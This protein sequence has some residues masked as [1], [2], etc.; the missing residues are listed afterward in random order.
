[1]NYF[2]QPPQY[3]LGESFTSFLA[4]FESFCESIDAKD[5]TRKHVFL[6]SLPSEMKFEMQEPDRQLY[7]LNFDDLLEKANEVAGGKQSR[8]ARQKLITRCQE[9]GE[10]NRSFVTALHQLGELAYPEKADSRIKNDVLYNVLL[11]GLRDKHHVDRLVTSNV[12]KTDSPSFLETA[13]RL[14]TFDGSSESNVVSVIDTVRTTETAELKNVVAE[15]RKEVQELR[16]RCNFRS[17]A[18]NSPNRNGRFHG[19][20]NVTCYG[21]GRKG[22]IR[23][24]C[25][26]SRHRVYE[27]EGDKPQQDGGAPTAS[28]P[29]SPSVT[30]KVSTVAGEL[31][32][33][34]KVIVNS[35]T[36]YAL[37]DT[38]AAVTVVSES[39]FQSRAHSELMKRPM[40][41][42]FVGAGGEPLSITGM[43]RINIA[44]GSIRT[45]MIVYV[46][47]NLTEDCI[48]GLDFLQDHQ[49]IVDYKH[50]TL[51]AGNASVQLLRRPDSSNSIRF[52]CASLIESLFVP[53][54]T[55]IVVSCRV[56]DNFSDNDVV[57]V[58]RNQAFFDKYEILSASAVTK[59]RDHTTAQVKL[60]NFT[61]IGKFLPAGTNV[62]KISNICE[63]HCNDCDFT[64]C[65]VSELTET[66]QV[67]NGD[68]DDKFSFLCDELGLNELNVSEVQRDALMAV[69]KKHIAAFSLSPND[70]GQT[71]Q[72][73]HKIDTGDSVP[74]RQH[75]RRMSNKQKV[76]V[77]KLVDEMCADGIISPS[78]SPWSSPIVLVKKKDGCFRFCVDYRAVNNCTKKNSYP[79]PRVD[80]SLDQLSGCGYFTTLDLKAGYW[81]IPMSQGDKEKTAFT[82]HKGLF[83]FNVMP[84]GLA[85]APA[86]FQHLMRIV[87]NGIEWNGVLAY[88]DDIIVYARTF[89]AHLQHL[90][91]LL[92]R[93][94][95]HGLKL[96]PSKC[97][98]L[99]TEVNFLGH[100][101]SKSGVSC[102]PDKISCI[103]NWPTP[104]NV[105]DVQKFLGLASYYRK[106]VKDFAKLAA[107]L[108]DITKNSPKSFCWSKECNDVFVFLKNALTTAPVLKY[109]DF[110]KS[111]IVDTDASNT[112]VG[113]VL[114]QV[115]DGLEH[116]VAYAS[117]ALNK[118]ERNYSTTRKEL[119]AVVHALQKFRCYLDQPF[120]LRTDH[121]SLRWLWQAKDTYGQCARWF[122][123]LAEFDFKLVHRAGAKHQNADAL[124]R[125]PNVN[126]QCDAEKC[127]FEVDENYSTTHATSCK[128]ISAID[129]SECCGWTSMNV[130]AAQQ[131][132][133]HLSVVLDWIRKGHRPQAKE[134][135]TMS[136]EVRHYW[137]MFGEISL[138]HDCLYRKHEDHLMTERY[139]LLVPSALQ[140]DVME[141]LHQSAH[142]GGHLGIERTAQKI[143]ERFYWPRWRSDV[144]QFC[145][146][147]AM[148]DQRKQPPK[149]P[150]APLV[151]SSELEPMERIEIDVLGGLPT[152]NSGNRY[153]LVACDMYT[154]YMQAWPM[155]TQTAQ[156]TALT[157]YN[158][159]LTVH[160][161]PQ[162]IHSDQGGNF[163][164]LLF[165]ELIQLMG[166]AKSRTTAYHPEGNGGVER[167]NR[168][169]ISMLKNYVQRDA[170]TWDLSLS[171]IC[172]TYNASRHEETGVSPHFLLTGRDLRLPADLISGKPSFAPSTH[173]ISDLQDR[174][175]FVHEAVKSRL[176]KRRASMKQRYDQGASASTYEVG[177]VVMLKSTVLNT[178][179]PRKFHMPYNGPYRVVEVLPPVNY[180][181]ENMHKTCRKV[182]HFNRLK[183]SRGKF[184]PDVPTEL[185]AE[186]EPSNVKPENNL[187]SK[188]GVTFVKRG[189][190]RQSNETLGT[191]VN[192]R[193]RHTLR[194][195]TYY[196]A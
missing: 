49:C 143:S 62:A 106:F 182:V 80:E 112:A 186:S 4:S 79:L 191:G 60:A 92:S 128:Q 183:R 188:G 144:D 181:I 59:I 111:F 36:T 146:E 48:L 118:V 40:N 34:A 178:N 26:E 170:Q 167:N 127:P 166:C 61:S 13:K 46:C 153:I 136:S 39:F 103:V 69:I 172:A 184:Q 189:P 114:S 119:L 154:K 169:I 29:V 157:L 33:Y 21:C 101:V 77:D 174:M 185:N 5:A 14:L 104:V 71:D 66:P 22:H 137:S 6:S 52:A 31:F 100:V 72:V 41:V 155:R 131:N 90:D 37:I 176:E 67:V 164:S 83:E 171:A 75:P 195:P 1:M 7:E 3:R 156:E 149:R 108:Y 57:I 121:A 87:L 74:I 85:N 32:K 15:L 163:E 51:A 142:G 168:T 86:T 123:L 78:K 88:L 139:Q 122:E 25:P 47:K 102:D 17:Y 97:N 58:E 38:G 175:T 125:L 151:P 115:H 110:S 30:Y 84:F 193:P 180:V 117:R 113:C 55:E 70:L 63:N 124:S 196:C 107:P 89:D 56:K 116:P 50:K 192:L 147:C 141:S 11:A 2:C 190:V 53:P 194:R 44:I 54:F 16:E 23:R 109:P 165:K 162:R 145:T 177:D 73:S 96:K 12:G 120:L 133:E 24:Y 10:S 81:Q 42:R 65:T 82:C 9:I 179:E 187:I 20:E 68:E 160:G 93:L 152:T 43:A 64:L 35:A 134:M 138:H 91:A 105:K 158:N 28:Q 129:M 161:V 8:N 140:A 173:V 94:T 95:A 19:L 18:N 27:R 135:K 99:K 126:E 132:D 76:E 45:Q 98:F 130:S 148:C 150:K 159:W